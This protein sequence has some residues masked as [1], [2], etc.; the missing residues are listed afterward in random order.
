MAST[1]CY[2]NTHTL[3]LSFIR[4]KRAGFIICSKMNYF[5]KNVVFSHCS[6]L[7]SFAIQLDLT[8]LNSPRHNQNRIFHFFSAFLHVIVSAH[9]MC[10]VCCVGIE[11]QLNTIAGIV[12]IIVARNERCISSNA[13][14]DD[15]SNHRFGCRRRRWRWR[16]RICIK[17]F[18]IQQNSASFNE[19]SLLSIC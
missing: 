8:Q 4:G 13:P 2:L 17:G 19:L 10:A 3:A 14:H 11:R 1:F 16:V 18:H 15:T 7:V 9:C 12:A 5:P 6:P